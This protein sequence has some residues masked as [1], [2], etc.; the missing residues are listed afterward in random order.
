MNN[1]RIQDE[2]LLI[3]FLAG[4][5]TDA[6][7]EHVRRRLETDSEFRQLHRD[8]Q[9]TNEAIALIPVAE[10]S[11]DLVGRTM[12]KIHAAR[13]TEALLAREELASHGMSRPTFSLR[14]AVAMV[15]ALV[16]MAVV[17]IPSVQS[18][19]E[20]NLQNLCAS[21][22]GQIGSGLLRFAADHDHQ[23]PAPEARDHR[24]WLPADGEEYVSNSSGLFR[25]I[26]ADA[27]YAQ[28]QLFQDPAVS[29]SSFEVT[30]SMRDF[31]AAENISYSY[32]HMVT[33]APLR[34][35]RIG[36]AAEEMAI[37]GDQTPLFD[38]GRFREDRLNARASDNHRQ[39]GQN[40]LYVSGHTLWADSPDVGVNGNNIFRAER[41]YRYS[42]VEAPAGPED[43]FLLPAYTR[44]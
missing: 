41:V 25:L 5:C 14:E 33:D 40:V 17:F 10:G 9:H 20:R 3:D 7:A 44:D 29:T 36:P 11:E 16:L 37:L 24:R 43:T 19:R 12:A 27:R 22:V 1:D 21:Q 34:I 26:R 38:H 31:P 6:Q 30:D 15:A 4:Q 32:Q 2:N 23:L 42:G 28:P 13:R 18:A 39:R 8:L 35:D